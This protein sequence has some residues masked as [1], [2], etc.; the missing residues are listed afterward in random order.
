MSLLN[1]ADRKQTS[2]A[3]NSFRQKFRSILSTPP[4]PVQHDFPEQLL[5]T[6]RTS[7]VR[8][9][10]PGKKWLRICTIERWIKVDWYLKIFGNASLKRAHS[11]G[12]RDLSAGIPT[13]GVASFADK[14]EGRNR[15][16]SSVRACSLAFINCLILTIGMIRLYSAY[17]GNSFAKFL[18]RA[19]VPRGGISAHFSGTHSILQI[20][21]RI[22][23][24][25]P[26]QPEKDT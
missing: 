12:A 3:P 17:Q 13:A 18:P 9:F 24:T 19:A 4:Y 21:C 2:T 11:L 5:R 26:G 7:K 23:L 14:S 10:Q 20:T 6:G 16:A 15:K 25:S 8:E 22:K 1:Q